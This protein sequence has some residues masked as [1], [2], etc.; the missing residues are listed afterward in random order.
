MIRCANFKIQS[1]RYCLAF[2]NESSRTINWIFAGFTVL[3][4]VTDTNFESQNM[5]GMFL[6]S[7]TF[8]KVAYSEITSAVLVRSLALLVRTITV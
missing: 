1:E 6:I 4:F 2:K 5:V 3:H 7:S 8:S